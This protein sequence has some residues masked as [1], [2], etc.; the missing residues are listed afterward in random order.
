M[1]I[2]ESTPTHCKGT[3]SLKN[4]EKGEHISLII[5]FFQALHTDLVKQE[6]IFSTNIMLFISF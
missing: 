2:L 4:G 6:V 1:C 5:Q 3:G